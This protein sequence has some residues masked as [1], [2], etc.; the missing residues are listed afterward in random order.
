MS[1]IGYFFQWS[2]H[3]ST[4]PAGLHR[5]ISRFFMT[6]DG[7]IR[8][9][10][11]QP[12]SWRSTVSPGQTAQF[13]A[14]A[15]WRAHCPQEAMGEADLSTEHS[16]TSKEPRLP[17]P[18]VDPGG[19]GRSQGTA[20]EGPSQAVGLTWR[21]RDR[22]TFARL[23]ASSTRSRMGPITVTFVHD[24]VGKPPRVA[25]SV[26]RKVGNAVVRN[27]V[28]RRLRAIVDDAAPRLASGAYL[29]SAGPRTAD[30]TFDDLRSA[31][32]GALDRMTTENGTRNG[33]GERP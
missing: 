22:T 21:I 14:R 31:V 9:E 24:E 16:Q 20:S 27:L 32:G 18:D 13:L 17:P 19:P 12:G 15:H 10:T 28:R 7:R 8:A 2:G 25:Y 3:G 29:V 23:R 5:L 33:P 11:W 1:V 26:G 6:F 4:A 30:M